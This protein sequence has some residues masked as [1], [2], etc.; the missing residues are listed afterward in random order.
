MSLAILE[1]Y[2]LVGAQMAGVAPT[3]RFF[4]PTDEFWSVM[5]RFKNTPIF[6]FGA[7]TGETVEEARALGFRWS[8]CDHRTGPETM[9]RGVHQLNALRVP[10]TEGMTAIACR[11]DHSGWVERALRR[12]LNHNANAI[13]VSKGRNAARDIGDL[14]LDRPFEMIESVGAEGEAMWIFHAD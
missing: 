12:A 9:L 5:S 14:L 10:L 1:L 2:D 13:Y 8:G 3:L 6:E 11:P 4:T 7:G